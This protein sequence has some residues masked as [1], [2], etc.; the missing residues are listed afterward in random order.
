LFQNHNELQTN[1]KYLA[2]QQHQKRNKLLMM[3]KQWREGDGFGGLTTTF[4]YFNIRRTTILSD[5]ECT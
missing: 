1:I 2:Q 5:N 4:F 3:N